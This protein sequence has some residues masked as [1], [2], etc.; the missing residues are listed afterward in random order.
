MES[1][2]RRGVELDGVMAKNFVYQDCF[3]VSL[4]SLIAKY[5]ALGEVELSMVLKPT[6]KLSVRDV[7]AMPA[8]DFIDCMRVR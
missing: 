5:L 7:K 1:A 3:C 4:N 2:A 6:R 8:A